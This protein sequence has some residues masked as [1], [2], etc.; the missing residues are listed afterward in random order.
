MGLEPTIP[1][2]F[3][4]QNRKPVRCHYA[5]KPCWILMVIQGVKSRAKLEMLKSYT[6][7]APMLVRKK[8]VGREVEVLQHSAET[9]RGFY[10]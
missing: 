4:K 7:D 10:V 5:T 3:T 8:S 2:I 9:L 1:G 6:R